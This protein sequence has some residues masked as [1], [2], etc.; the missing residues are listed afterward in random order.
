MTRDGHADSCSADNPYAVKAPEVQPRRAQAQV[1]SALCARARVS[2][3]V[4]EFVT[5]LHTL[6]QPPAAAVTQVTEA[7]STDLPN[8]MGGLEPA[9]GYKAYARPCARRARLDMRLELLDVEK[10]RWHEPCALGLPPT[11]NMPTRAVARSSE[12]CG[13]RLILLRG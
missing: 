3:R 12:L 2:T 10:A 1:R 13:G 7:A 5:H 4:C 9:R 11:S 6:S 8:G